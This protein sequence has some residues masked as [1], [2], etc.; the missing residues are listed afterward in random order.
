MNDDE[1]IAYLAGQSGAP[2]DPDERAQLDKLRG[3]LS[4]P[5]VWTEP[6]PDLQERIVG[7]IANAGEGSSCVVQTRRA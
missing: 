6:P 5:A 2:A 4:D 3:V 7:A 1:R